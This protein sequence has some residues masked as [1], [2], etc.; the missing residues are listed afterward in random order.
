MV[1]F[2]RDGKSVLALSTL[3]RETQ[4]LVRRYLP[5]SPHISPNLPPR[6]AGAGAAG[7]DDGRGA[8]DDCLRPEKQHGGHSSRRRHQGGARGGPR[9]PESSRE[10]AERQ[11]RSAEISRDQPR[12][13]EIGRDHTEI[14]GMARG[15][16]RWAAARVRVE[17][18]ALGE[19]SRRT[20]ANLSESRR[21]SAN[22]APRSGA[23]RR[24][25]CGVS[26][27]PAG[28]TR[29]T[30]LKRAALSR[31]KRKSWGRGRAPA[32]PRVGCAPRQDER[33][34]STKK[35]AD[36]HAGGGA[37]R[38]G[39]RAAQRA[40]LERES[41]LGGPKDSVSTGASRRW[42]ERRGRPAL[43]RSLCKSLRC[44]AF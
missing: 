5:K 9:V 28:R 13:A 35:E 40:E 34:G 15:W 16:C 27:R 21:I 14:G 10:A 7:R 8:R 19:S 37:G 38:A 44:R 30:R 32:T 26:G 3:G 18:L 36:Q 24:R 2:A 4:A 20:S 11:P 6:D 23:G 43:M 41:Q 22:L 33:Q 42:V 1:E 17:R 25:G 29:W 31:S 39:R 12:S